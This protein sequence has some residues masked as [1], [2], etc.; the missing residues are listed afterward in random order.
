M[1]NRDLGGLEDAKQI[2]AEIK[3][4]FMEKGLKARE[5]LMPVRVALTGKDKGPPLPYLLVVLGL[6]ESISRLREL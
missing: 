6:E 2:I 5:V 4:D 3:R 1:E